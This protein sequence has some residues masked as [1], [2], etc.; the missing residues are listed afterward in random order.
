MHGVT[1]SDLQTASLDPLILTTYRRTGLP[2]RSRRSATMQNG[3]PSSMWLRIWTRSF[4][5]RT[6]ALLLWLE[7]IES[8]RRA[9]SKSIIRTPI[10]YSSVLPVHTNLALDS[11]PNGPAQSRRSDSQAV[12]GQFDLEVQLPGPSILPLLRQVCTVEPVPRLTHAAEEGVPLHSKR[13]SRRS[14]SRSPV[15]IADVDF[16]SSPE[17]HQVAL[18]FD[19]V[20]LHGPADVFC[21]NRDRLLPFHRTHMPGDRVAT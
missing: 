6:R 9:K 12:S 3:A 4:V 20:G 19:R 18:A 13:R 17:N 14:A 21:T 1:T 11:Q 16:R 5:G 2:R 7:T 10:T 8:P 15:T